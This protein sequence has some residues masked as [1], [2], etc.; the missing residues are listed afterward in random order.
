MYDRV[1]IYILGRTAAQSKSTL[2]AGWR[3]LLLQGLVAKSKYNGKRACVIFFERQEGRYTIKLD[4][5]GKR[6]RV[7]PESVVPD[8]TDELS[9]EVRPL[10]NFAHR[11]DAHALSFERCLAR[12]R[13]SRPARS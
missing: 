3:L 1:S 12:S 6:L 13:H 9:L 10:W 8:D 5:D 2:P 7:K 11:L 4:D